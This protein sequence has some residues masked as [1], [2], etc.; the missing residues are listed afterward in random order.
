MT[1]ALV[2]APPEGITMIEA[3]QQA[4]IEEMRRDPSVVVM[5]EDVAIKGGVFRATKGLLE[6]FGDRRV[7]DTPI[8]EAVIA[9]AAIGAA[10]S[11]LRPVAEFQFA[12]YIHPAYE[13]IVN[14]AATMRW[15]TVG[16]VGV[17]IVLRAPFGGGISGGIYH[18]Q[19]VEA[20]YCHVPGLKVVVPATPR[21]AKGLLKAAIRDD[22][23]VLFFEHKKSYRRYRE[24]VPDDEV[25]PIGKAR[26]DREGDTVS[27]ITYGVGV[28]HA[29]E[30]AAALAEEGIEIEILDLRTLAPL[31]HD[32]IAR[33]VG[34]THRALIVH[35]AN[36]TMGIGA[37][38]AA[39]IADD[40]FMDLDAPVRRVCGQDS[41][42][43]YN[44]PE[45]QE[46]IPDPGRVAEAV[47][48][49]ASY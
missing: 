41:H 8:A 39:F 7:L 46:I 47:R 1:E 49:L 43:P 22:D 42:L 38:I 28:H 32:A 18:S 26:L 27:V 30:A 4:L 15:R 34:R 3:V 44:A 45:E 11:G 33:T 40:L 6:E 13:Q 19:S 24:L 31:D 36:R 12:D 21:D 16:N 37:E 10:M 9:G 17:P 5:G 29:R 48:R 35:E 23:P 20:L 2:A 14:Q 25:L